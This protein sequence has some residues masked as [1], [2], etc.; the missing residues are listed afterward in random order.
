VLPEGVTLRRWRRGTRQGMGWTELTLRPIYSFNKR[1]EDFVDLNSYNDYLEEFE[2][3]S[4]SSS[5]AAPLWE[6]P[7][8]PR[9]SQRST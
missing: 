2:D 5:L 7:A 8:D 3:L 4:A 9:I 6:M 1:Q